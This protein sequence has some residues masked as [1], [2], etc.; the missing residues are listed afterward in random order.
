MT[1]YFRQKDSTTTTDPNFKQPPSSFDGTSP[2][3]A[4]AED[5]RTVTIDMQQMHSSAI[6]QE[7]LAKTGAVPVAPTPQDQ[8]ELREMEDLKQRGV[9]DRVRVK[10]ALDQQRAESAFLRAATKSS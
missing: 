3:P 6:L 9:V 7:F 4:P 1:L 2:A 10:K 8:D 5:E